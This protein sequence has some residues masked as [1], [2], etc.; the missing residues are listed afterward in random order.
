MMTSAS[1]S[2]G[3]GAPAVLTLRDESLALAPPRAPP[4]RAPLPGVGLA[5]ARRALPS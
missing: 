3:G 2:G 4:P 1:T 5:L